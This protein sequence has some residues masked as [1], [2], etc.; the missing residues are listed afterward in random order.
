MNNPPAITNI[1]RANKE[2]HNLLPHSKTLI[3]FDA[4]GNPL[5]YFGDQF[6]D[7]SCYAH[8]YTKQSIIEFDLDHASPHTETITN[9]IKII[10][11]YIIFARKRRDNNITLASIYNSF[12]IIRKISYMCLDFNCDFTTIK[13]NGLFLK[14][15]RNNLRDLSSDSQ[16][17]YINILYSINKAGMLYRIDNF[18]FDENYIQEIK[19]IKSLD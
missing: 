14:A 5:S 2:N 15:L 10:L 11:F 13:K 16:R 4:L 18:G 17:K 3:S 7:L 9:Q 19:K 12:Y 1:F 8:I 6:W